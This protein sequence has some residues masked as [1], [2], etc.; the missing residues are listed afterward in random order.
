MNYREAAGWFS[1]EAAR[2]DEFAN[3][4]IGVDRVMAKRLVEYE[5]KAAE[6][7]RQLANGYVLVPK[8]PTPEMRRRGNEAVGLETP[9]RCS[10]VYKAMIAAAPDAGGTT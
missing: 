7:F 8:E 4:L 1:Q 9:V 5:A 3:S 10:R 6:I 2:S